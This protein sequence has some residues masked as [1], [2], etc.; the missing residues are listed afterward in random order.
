[1]L[2]NQHTRPF[3]A[4]AFL[5]G[6]VLLAGHGLMTQNGLTAQVFDGGGLL[7]GLNKARD[8]LSGAGLRDDADIIVT[9]VKIIN[10]LLLF[11][12]L[13]V[14]VSF[15]VSG[16]LFILGFGSDTSIQRAK[17]IMIWSVVGL[18]VILFAFLL[19]EFI[20]TASTA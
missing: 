3:F 11:V 12:A 1:M 18:V 9:I 15:V 4:L 14:L 20:I 7:E 2:P 5:I 17:K 8:E 10:F 19:T 13:A 16:F 6:V